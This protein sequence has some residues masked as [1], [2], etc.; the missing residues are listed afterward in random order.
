MGMSLSTFEMLHG[1]TM[2]NISYV[3][4]GMLIAPPKKK[5]I[6]A[7]FSAIEARK[8]AWLAD[9]TWRLEVFRTHGMI[10]EASASMM[11]N[12]PFEDFVQHKKVHNKHHPLRKKGKVG[13][14]ACGYQ[15]G[16]SAL[17]TMGA[18]KEGLLQEELK[19]IVTKW[20]AANPNIKLLWKTY[21]QL[22]LAAYKN[23]GKVFEGGKCRFLYT[24][25]FLKIQ[26]PSKRVLHYYQPS[27]EKVTIPW[28][29]PDTGE[30]KTFDKD[31]LSYWGEKV[32]DGGKKVWG[33]VST[34]GGKLT[35]NVT[36]ASSRDCLRDAMFALEAN[37][38]EIVMHIHDE[39]VLE[40]PMNFGSVKEVCDIMAIDAPWAPGLPLR[41]A[42]FETDRYKK[43]D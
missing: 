10:Y 35:E 15:G 37:G 1:D 25:P 23:P 33:I 34:Y 12:V 14:L 27:T 2:R 4:R 22:S 30:F 29:D 43:D 5:F 3:T 19:P 20:R 36:Q 26:L 28:T 40:V 38:Y 31:Q 41:A 11:F 42:G 32:I 7:D 39:V 18:L 16:E 8:L 13:D 6:V 24:P 17:V 21:D 9:E